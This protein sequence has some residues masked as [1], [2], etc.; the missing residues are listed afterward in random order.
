MKNLELDIK[1]SNL[2]NDLSHDN[3]LELLSNYQFWDGF[4]NYL[5]DYIPEDL[6]AVLRLK[7]EANDL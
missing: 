3:R 2:W 5:Y 6:K 7:I 4:S 1:A